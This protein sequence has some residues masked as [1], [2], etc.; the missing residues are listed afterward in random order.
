[1]LNRL[2]G[3]EARPAPPAWNLMKTI[4]QTMVFWTVFLALLP[5]GVYLTESALDL[6]H[7]RFA[8]PFGRLAG[9]MLFVLGGSLGL[10]SG[11]TM[12]LKGRGTPLPLDCPREMV[13]D[14]PYRYVRNPMAMAG[15]AQGVAVGLF[16]G[17]PA[18]ILYALCGGPLWNVLVR[19]WEERDLEQ[20]FGES[21]V[22]YRQSV[23]CW[24]PHSRPYSANSRSLQKSE[25]RSLE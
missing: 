9:A 11:I 4:L 17:S 10:T 20:R 5:A 12:A 23:R 25:G 8:G 18:V 2:R 13:I 19:P 14:G 1:M 15:I 16:L 6:D 7:W 24:W 22:R 3:R 21:F